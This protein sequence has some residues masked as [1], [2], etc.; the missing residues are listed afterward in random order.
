MNEIRAQEQEDEAGRGETFLDFL[1]PLGAGL[2]LA[3]MPTGEL[4]QALESGE[5]LV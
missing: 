1:L 5:M 3:I 2:D 4:A